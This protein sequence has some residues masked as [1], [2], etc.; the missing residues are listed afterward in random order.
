MS[1]PVLA[2]YVPYWDHAAARTVIDANVEFINQVSPFWYAI[3]PDGSVTLQDEE[4][5][6]VDIAWLEGL[7]ARGIRVIPT[8]SNHYPER[9]APDVVRSVLGDPATRAAHID[10]IVSLVRSGPFDGVD[11]DYEELGP[12]DRAV[13]ATFIDELGAAL[14]AQGLLLAV[15]V[16][17]DDIG[18]Q[19]AYDLGVIGRAADQVRLMAYTYSY[20]GSDPGAIAP[21]G[22]V[23]SR[24]RA[25]AA[26]MPAD[27]L[28][29]GLAS[30][31]Y[32]WPTSGSAEGTGIGYDQALARIPAGVTP[33]WTEDAEW[34]FQ[35]SDGAREVWYSDADTAGVRAALA[36]DF[37]LGGVF[38]WRSGEEDPDSWLRIHSETRPE[39]WRS[40][41]EAGTSYDGSRCG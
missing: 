39:A 19:D 40:R 28:V 13:F 25:A 16:M 27:R 22:W 11:I 32:D 9:W 15:D 18:P 24:V 3:R 36:S 31:G 6:V 12:Q 38:L 33:R 17:P 41:C 8:V 23:A 14:H 21:L 20:S 29:L 2:A 34:T 30:F 7:R 1:E 10:A 4:N 35:H 26:Q 37:G 5:T